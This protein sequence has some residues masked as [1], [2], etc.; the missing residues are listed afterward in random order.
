M[1][2]DIKIDEYDEAFIL[3][4]V[5]IAHARSRSLKEVAAALS[6]P[7]EL[8]FAWKDT[9][10]NKVKVRYIR[11][12]RSGDKLF[13]K[14]IIMEKCDDCGSKVVWESVKTFVI[15]REEDVSLGTGDSGDDGILGAKVPYVRVATE[16]IE[17]CPVCGVYVIYNLT[18]KLTK[19]EA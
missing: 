13:K 8:L 4:A 7:P 2:E 18:E 3:R 15:H 14:P 11:D 12:E 1:T 5:A 10:A 17:R 19:S 16:K 6:I 9:Y